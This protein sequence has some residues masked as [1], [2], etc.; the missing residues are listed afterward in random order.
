MSWYI[1]R[2][3]LEQKCVR[4]L[5]NT[6]PVNIEPILIY[7]RSKFY[8]WKLWP[9]LQLSI[10]CFHSGP[11]RD[12]K[13]EQDAKTNCQRRTKQSIAHCSKKFT[14]KAEAWMHHLSCSIFE[15]RKCNIPSPTRSCKYGRR[16]SVSVAFTKDE[17]NCISPFTAMKR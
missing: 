9:G 7:S 3:L 15:E 11:S 1:F 8:S 2:Q 17:L 12:R 13:A 4:H 10:I 16:L 6:I 5:R 14:R